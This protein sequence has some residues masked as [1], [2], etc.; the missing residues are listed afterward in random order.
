[1]S[2]RPPRPALDQSPPPQ[3]ADSVTQTE[4]FSVYCGGFVLRGRLRV[5]GCPL[6][7]RK[8]QSTTQ[9]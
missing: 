5:L 7:T 3:Q 9:M 2:V 8:H 1:M 4:E 6:A